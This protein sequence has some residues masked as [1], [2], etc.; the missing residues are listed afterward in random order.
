MTLRELYATV[1]EVSPRSLPCDECG[2]CGGE[3]CYWTMLHGEVRNA[4]VPD[5]YHVAR[6][7]AA[8]NQMWTARSAAIRAYIASTQTGPYR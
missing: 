2:A 1:A 4:E 6:T 7:V 5:R 3:F 8:S